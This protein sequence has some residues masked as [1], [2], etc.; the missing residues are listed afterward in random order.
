[1]L[2][3]LQLVGATSVPLKVTVLVPSLEPKF[4]PVTVTEVPAGPDVGERLVTVGEE[5]PLVGRNVAI[6]M[7]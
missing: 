6:I 1:M 7:M 2:V 5:W 3:E 4:A